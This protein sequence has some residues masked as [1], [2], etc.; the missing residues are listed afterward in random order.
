MTDPPPTGYRSATRPPRRRAPA[1]PTPAAPPTAERVLARDGRELLLRPIQP[2][3]AP[4]L[5][6]AFKR[7]TPDQVRARF[8]YRINEVSEVMAARWADPDP[9]T[10]AAFVATDPDGGEIRGEARLLIDSATAGAE[11]A[12]AIDPAFTGQGVGRALMLKLIEQAHRRGLVDLWGEV[13][14][15]NALMLDLASRLGAQRQAV[16]DEP[17]LVRVRFDLAALEVPPGD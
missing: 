15:E 8:F 7:L 9:E 12:I 13:L 11:F 16:A 10:T 3:D 2:S 4:A 5:R 14:T 17:G 6:R 1:A